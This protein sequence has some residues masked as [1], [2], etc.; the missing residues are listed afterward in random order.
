MKAIELIEKRIKELEDM[1]RLSLE[2]KGRLKEL[3]ALRREL[4]K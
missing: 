2:G 3:K 1:T 4:T